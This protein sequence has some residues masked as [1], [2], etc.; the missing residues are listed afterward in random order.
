MGFVKKTFSEEEQSR[1]VALCASSTCKI[2]QRAAQQIK[3]LVW[4]IFFFFFNS[5]NDLQL[6][7]KQEGCR[8]SAGKK[9]YFSHSEHV[10]SRG[11]V[12]LGLMDGR[13]AEEKYNATE[14][15]ASRRST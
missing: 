10:Y 13:A 9:H 11:T 2:V 4:Q 5:Q 3:P 6:Q 1:T 14:R 7:R 15:Q 8:S 12:I